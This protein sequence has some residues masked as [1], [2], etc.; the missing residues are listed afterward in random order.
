MSAQEESLGFTTKGSVYNDNSLN[1]SAGSIPCWRAETGSR[2]ELGAQDRVSAGGAP[3]HR[4]CSAL[5]ARSRQAFTLLT[6]SM[7]HTNPGKAEAAAAVPLRPSLAR[8]AKSSH[9]IYKLPNSS[10]DEL[11]EILRSKYHTGDG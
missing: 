5:R 11:R 3:A 8:S 7:M 10:D 4:H 2:T 1:G 9:L 6:D